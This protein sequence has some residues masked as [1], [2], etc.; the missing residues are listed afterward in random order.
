MRTKVNVPRSGIVLSVLLQGLVFAAGAHAAPAAPPVE[1]GVL[2]LSNVKIQTATPAQLEAIAAPSKATTKSGLRAYKDHESGHFREQTPEE[3]V[4]AGAATAAAPAPTAAMVRSS[5][6]GTAVMLDET[7]MSNAV[8]TKDASGKY[9]L[10]CVVGTEAT[11][12]A[13]ANTKTVKGH[14]HDH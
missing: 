4:E 2:K 8:V 12:K 14:G 1:A 5:K 7:F 6:G 9:Q 11:A 3:M 10:D 13:L